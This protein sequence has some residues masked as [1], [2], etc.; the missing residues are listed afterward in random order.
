VS[1]TH[2]PG[3]LILESSFT[4]LREAARDRFPGFLVKTLVPDQYR[5]LTDV[6]LVSCPVL[7]IHSPDDEIV[8][9]PHGQA[10]YE[11]AA[12]PKEFAVIRGSHNRGYLE[13]QPHYEAA[14]DSF[15]A[16]YLDRK[17]PQND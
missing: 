15:L 2:P 14:L 11:G 8:P 1:R 10:L 16:Q 4:S 17:T 13:S 12:G 9:F 5:T 6:S 3:A 7:I